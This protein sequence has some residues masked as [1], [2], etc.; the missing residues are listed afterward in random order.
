MMPS[1][2]DIRSTLN[3]V[4]KRTWKIVGGLL[5]FGLLMRLVASVSTNRN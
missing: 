2:E 4:P 3:A 5:A 1:K